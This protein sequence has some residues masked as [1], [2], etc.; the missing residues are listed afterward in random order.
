MIDFSQVS[1]VYKDNGVIALKDISF[2]MNPGEMRILTGESGAGKTTLLKLILGEEKP[3]R[4]T[5]LINGNDIGKIKQ[6]KMPQYRR[7]IGLVFQDF[8]LVNNKTVYDNV[9]LPKQI[10]GAK[11]RDIRAQVTNALRI[12]GLESEF[13]RPVNELSGGEMQRVGIARAMVNNPDLILA[14]EPTGNLDPKN[15]E[16]IFKLL[17]KINELGSTILVATHDVSTAALT[18]AK[19]LRLKEGVLLDEALMK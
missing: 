18:G 3:T 8:R 1:K 7:S 12:V 14:D 16:E 2:H 6:S 9:A 13:Y 11:E 17:K 10:C 15:S 5:I 19:E 4:G